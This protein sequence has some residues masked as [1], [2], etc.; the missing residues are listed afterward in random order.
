MCSYLPLR[1]HPYL[2][3]QTLTTLNLGCNDIEGEGAQ[4]IAQALQNNTVR[5]VF[6]FSTT[7]SSLSFITDTHHARS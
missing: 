4:H 1:I 7:H 5:D 2:S 6:F 3:I